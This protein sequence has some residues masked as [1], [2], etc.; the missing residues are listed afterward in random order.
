MHKAM[1]GEMPECF[2]CADSDPPPC[3]TSCLCKDL[4]VH[5]ECLERLLEARGNSRCG[6]CGADYKDVQCTTRRRFL[7][8]SPF[9]LMVAVGLTIVGLLGCSAFLYVA[10]RREKSLPPLILWLAQ[11]LF[12]AGLMCAVGVAICMCN[13]QGGP[14]GVWASRY[15]EEQV[16]CVKV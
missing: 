8:C 4:H 11:L 10:A 6:V 12:G 3:K 7:W 1:A 16:F 13:S 15:V 9:T 5:T 14:R 2:I